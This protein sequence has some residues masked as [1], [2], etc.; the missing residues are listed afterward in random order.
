[1]R[2]LSIAL[3]ISLAALFTGPS[4]GYPMGPAYPPQSQTWTDPVQLLADAL[5]RVRFFA[6]SGIWRDPVSAQG[7]LETEVT[8]YFDFEF[9]AAWSARPFYQQMNPAQQAR[10]RAG[11][12]QRFI[13]L[14]VSGMGAYVNPVPQ[15]RFLP[16]RRVAVDRADVPTEIFMQPGITMRLMFHLR[17]GPAGWQIVD[18]SMDGMSGLFLFRQFLIGLVRQHG[19][20]VLLTQ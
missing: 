18:A 3:F 15:V 10:F 14:I 13:G 11:M 20:A 7:F 8:P 6:A 4:F 9:M 12:K 17:S 16:A 1:M 19:P 5:S 2:R